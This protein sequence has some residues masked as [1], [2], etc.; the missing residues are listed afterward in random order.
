MFRLKRLSHSGYACQY[1]IVFC[2]KYQHRVFKDE[3][4]S[5]TH[6]AM[7]EISQRKAAIEVLELN[8]QPDQIHRV[9]SLAPQYAVSEFVGYL[10][11][12]LAFQWFRQVEHFGKRFWGRPLWST[13]Y[14][15]STIGVNEEEIRTYVK[16]QEKPIELIEQRLL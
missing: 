13:G 6:R 5:Y 1:H 10:K 3:M 14:C 7:I 12:K 9:V 16:W 4:A 2:P 11:G 15:G 8:G